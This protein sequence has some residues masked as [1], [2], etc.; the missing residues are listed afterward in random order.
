[1]GTAHQSTM[2]S[3]NCMI[4]LLAGLTLG[5]SSDV[6]I[7]SSAEVGKWCDDN[8]LSQQL[9]EGLDKHGVTGSVLLFL[10]ESDLIEDLQITSKLERKKILL[11]L[12]EIQTDGVHDSK[13]DTTA[14][15]VRNKLE[16]EIK[17]AVAAE[18]DSQHDSRRDHSDS[19]RRDHSDSRRWDRFDDSRR[20]NY[21]PLSVTSS[22]GG[23]FESLGNGIGPTVLVS[24][25]A[26]GVLCSAPIGRRWLL[27]L[28]ILALA[29]FYG[30]VGYGLWSLVGGFF[31]LVGGFFSALGALGSLFSGAFSLVIGGVVILGFLVCIS[32]K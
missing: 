25:M 28:A 5:L 7:W 23:F 17:T 20:R 12:K 13:Q 3:L 16:A 2:V 10:D 11:A 22:G 6:K 4:L 1:M 21:D 27:A 24:A 29:L 9:K 31:S 18:F 14:A 8:S 30:A 15:Q 32:A 19:R 26:L